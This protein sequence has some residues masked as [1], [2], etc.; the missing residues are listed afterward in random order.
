MHEDD[1]EHPPHMFPGDPIVRIT[2]WD[3][4]LAVLVLLFSVTYC[5]LQ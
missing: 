4:V 1:D 5:S 2:R 3:I